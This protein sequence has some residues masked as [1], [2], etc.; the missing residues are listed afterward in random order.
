VA[1]PVAR[2][3]MQY[4]MGETLTPIVAGAATD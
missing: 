3:V 2:Q 1:A 4:L